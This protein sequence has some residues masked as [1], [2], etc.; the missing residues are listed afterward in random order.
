[1]ADLTT[2]TAELA[3]MKQKMV[4]RLVAQGDET[5]QPDDTMQTIVDHFD[6]LRTKIVN[7]DKEIT[8]N[9]EYTADEGYTGLG[10]VTV[11][12]KAEPVPKF[13]ATIDS[14]LGDVDANGVLQKPTG[15]LDLVFGGVKNIA[16]RSLNNAFSNTSSVENV[17]FP[18]LEQVDGTYAV[19]SGFSSST[20]VK[21]FKADKLKTIN[22]SYAFSSLFYYCNSIT[23]IS[24]AELETI[25]V[26]DAFRGL[27]SS[28]TSLRSY[29]FNKLKII[30]GQSVFYSAFQST[31]QIEVAAFPSLEEITNGNATFQNAFN[32]SAKL[33]TV[34]FPKL[35]RVAGAGAFSSAFAS[36]YGITKVNFDSLESL[37]DNATSSM[38]SSCNK[39]PKISFPSLTTFKTIYELANNMFIGC[40][41]LT[42]IHFRADA[43]ATIEALGNYSSKFGATNATIFFDL[44]GTI[45]VN[46]VAYARNEPNSIYVEYDKTYVAWADESGN[47][48]YTTAGA[49][50]AVGTVVYSDEGTTQVGTVSA[51]A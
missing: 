17:D 15:T 27:A 37:S 40:T 26:S 45:T 50:P 36:S 48:V 29:N 4:D 23:S 12:V 3:G 44:I 38:F 47:I 18:D 13:G 10:K 6:N 21:S 16:D 19:A 39:L 49:E 14:F 42:E 30:N 51:V 7:Q 46:G 2:L 22:G 28:S 9:G 25:N 33:H 8:A 43:Q 5:I 41:L 24:F 34:F 31:K 20:S 11:D 35:R 1:M 32:Y